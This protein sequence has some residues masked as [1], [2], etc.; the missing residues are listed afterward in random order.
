MR[1][2]RIF[3]PFKEE[4]NNSIILNITASHHLKVINIK[5]GQN[6]EL[7]NGS[8]YFFNAKVT[9]QNK[10]NIT[11]KRTSDVNF[12]KKQI[13]SINIAVA[14]I[15]SFDKVIR[16]VCQSGIDSIT[17]VKTKK[18]KFSKL[19]SEKKIMRWQSIAFNSCEQSG[20]NW[21]PKIYSSS[22]QEWISSSKSKSK[23]FLDPKAKNNIQKVEL[24]SSIDFVVG[25]EGGFSEEEK[26]FFKKNNFIGISCG[27]LT[28]RTE[29]MPIVA[30]SMIKA[31]YG[32]KK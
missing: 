18:T 9:E 7:F 8:G 26:I 32:V 14:D 12:Q 19:S 15:R 6:V 10:K 2:P 23:I 5:E 1:I 30:L 29:T 20:L 13:P 21:V 11:L 27:N 3:Y 4:E 22:L 24:F 31:L 25:P 17:S 28:F 16:E